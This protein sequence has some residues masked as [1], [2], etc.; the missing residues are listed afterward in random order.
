LSNSAA[1]P[2]EIWKIEIEI[3]RNFI[4]LVEETLFGCAE[5]DF[6][7]LSDFEIIEGDDIRLLEAYY[8]QKPDLAKLKEALKTSLETFD[9]PLPEIRLQRVE[10]EDWVSKS[11]KILKPVDAG[12]FFVYGSHDADKLPEDKIGLLVEA[13]QAFG[14]GQHETTNG[15]LRALCDLA[16]GEAPESA[17][18]LGCGSGILALAM[19][20]LWPIR[21][22]ASDIDPIATETSLLNARVNDVDIVE[23]TS[24]KA[25]LC[26]LTSDGMDDEILHK[27]GPYKVITANILA[28][29]LQEMAHDIVPHLTPKGH[30]ILSGLLASQEEAV[31]KAYEAEGLVLK[32]RYCLGEWNTLMLV[33]K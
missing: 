9:Q 15:C 25:G 11:Q 8:T 14:T 24:D 28:G 21:V 19:C 5:N 7:T 17:L 2:S 12:R 1:D 33:R 10:N 27:S 22:M 30:L 29:P 20:K 23:A 6:P 18:D 13:G 3:S 26:A 32:K 16:E 31:L 4:P